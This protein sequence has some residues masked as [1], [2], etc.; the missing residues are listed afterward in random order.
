TH[1]D[2]L[3]AYFQ[4]NKKINRGEISWQELWTLV[5]NELQCPEKLPDIINLSKKYSEVK[6]NNEII[7]LIDNLRKNGYKIGL[8]S[9]NTI[10][11]AGVMRSLGIDKHFDVF[12]ISAETGYVKPEKEAFKHLSDELDVKLHELIF[13]DD[14]EKSLSTSQECGYTPILYDNYQQLKA[15]LKYFEINTG[16]MNKGNRV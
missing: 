15:E 1:D 8:L 6:I 16:T 5:L 3:R 4:H 2:Y 12:H 13:I 14:S 7:Y 10:E 9:N 11:K